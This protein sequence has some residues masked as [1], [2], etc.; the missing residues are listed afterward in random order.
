MRFI[1]L[2][3]LKNIFRNKRRTLLTG[4]GIAIAVIT[5]IFGKG[6]MD[7]VYAP[8]KTTILDMQTAHIRIVDEEYIKKERLMPVNKFIN[9]NDIEEKIQS[10]PDIEVL[11]PRTKF[12]GL[13]AK[14]DKE[15]DGM[16]II[17][18]L[19]E[20]ETENKFLRNTDLE[21]GE[22]LLGRQFAD[23]YGIK[24]GDSVVIITPTR[25]GYLNGLTLEADEFYETN[26]NY[27]GKS[28]VFLHL[29]DAQ[30][31]LAYNENQA[32][33]L[34][35]MSSS[36][37]RTY[38]AVQNLLPEREDIDI[39]YYLEGESLMKYI[40][41]GSSFVYIFLAILFAIASIAIINTMVMALYERTKEIGMMKSL[42]LKNRHVFTVFI[43]E[44]IFITLMGVIIG[45]IIGS[46]L[47]YYFQVNG[48]DFTQAMQQIDMPIGSVW[49]TELSLFNV[50]IAV[51]MGIASGMFS[52]LFL[53]KRIWRIRPAEVLRG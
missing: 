7:G 48:M 42:G 12:G 18:L 8:M 6:F 14:E 39:A 41:I 47:T 38:K 10:A 37:S 26:I 15:A 35:V 34:M 13:V 44:T 40:E 9:Y 21:R 4:L 22:I 36:P 29:K 51:I 11:R 43:L 5:V 53:I 16:M 32:T 19:P 3:S 1:L 50:T 27:I 2:L 49:Y 24:R 31:L 52:S 45:V 23:E 28:T 20:R 25:Y 17:G 33:E 30:F 46:L